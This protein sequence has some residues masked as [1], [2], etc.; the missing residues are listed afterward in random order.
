VTIVEITCRDPVVSR[1]SRPFGANQGNRMRALEWLLPSVVAGSLRSALAISANRDFSSSV[2][3][4]LL[5]V[6]IAGPL[7]LACRKL[8]F[9]APQDCVVHQGKAWRA[10]PQ[11]SHSGGCDWPSPGLRPVQLADPR[12]PQDLKPDPAP[13][14]WPAD[15]C[16][17]WL[18]GEEIALDCR[19]LRHPKT[20]YRTHVHIDPDAGAAEEGAL[21]TTA[22]LALG[23]LPRHGAP[24]GAN[25]KDRFLPIKLAARLD[26][27][28]WC[29]EA[30]ANLDLLH[31]MG[32]ERR[33]IHCKTTTD[34]Q[35]WQCPKTIAAKLANAPRVKMMLATPAIFAEGWR[36][37]WLNNELVGTP[38]G[39]AVRLRLVGVSIQRWRAVSGWSLAAPRGPKPI[40]RMVPA[41]GVYF[42][43]TENGAG[44]ASDLA[45]RWLE[46][47]SDDEQDRRD[48]F[49]LALWG[50][51]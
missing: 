17:K 15:E 11:A 44:N 47:V 9:P 20:D 46:S 8:Y 7:P 34:T 29:A 22:A 41:G 37:A 30:A 4:D 14:W 23:A 1:D 35:A 28:E 39:A 12:A 21:F 2:V 19:F 3:Q 13:A 5:G 24:A 42:F 48:G 26:A 40:K 6:G 16:T 45:H 25:R 43:E 10:A 36:P 50:V 31:P 33:L 49:G 32:G 18:A 38:P 51:W 27:K